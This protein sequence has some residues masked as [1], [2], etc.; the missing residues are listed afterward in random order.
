MFKG[1]NV[2]ETKKIVLKS[3]PDPAN[4][5]VFH[6]G[7][8]DQVISGYI[9]DESTV[10]DFAPQNE[11]SQEAP[12]GE[13]REATVRVRIQYARRNLL[14]IKFGVRK[15]ENYFDPKQE[16]AVTIDAEPVKI[17]GSEYMTLPDEVIRGFQLRGGTAELA[18]E[19]RKINGL[20]EEEAK[21]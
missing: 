5:T 13:P 1:I 7:V 15:I 11:I 18:D 8:L 17:Y 6:I 21:N 10:F 16:K 4:P 20:S 3:D 19:I 2:N 9:E 12:A 14:M